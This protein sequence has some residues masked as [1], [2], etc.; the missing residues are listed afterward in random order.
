MRA[1][2]VRDLKVFPLFTGNQPPDAEVRAYANFLG[3]AVQDVLNCEPFRPNAGR[4][5]FK[6]YAAA[7]AHSQSDIFLDPD[8]G[9]AASTQTG[10]REHV[11]VHE[12]QHLLPT[13]S[14][15]LLLVY[16]DSPDRGNEDELLS[17]VFL[18]MLEPLSQAGLIFFAYYTGSA[19]I[20][21]VANSAG[22][23]RLD[24]SRRYLRDVVYVP[25]DKLLPG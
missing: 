2:A 22:Q 8:T 16:Q 18:R 15:R 20:V 23:S 14:T 21:F 25:A 24:A 19:N 13:G 9:I 3:F 11:T 10:S 7:A 12:L 4:A 17:E 5:E 6:H 1:G